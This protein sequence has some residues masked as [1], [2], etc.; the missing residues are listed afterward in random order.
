MIGGKLTL[1]SVAED[2]KQ[3]WGL[4]DRLQFS[5]K[6]DILSL[7]QLP[8]DRVDENQAGTDD[9]FLS[10]GFMNAFVVQLSLLAQF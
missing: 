10:G 4:F 1:L 9:Q 2:D 5:L 3:V 7:D 8:A 6:G